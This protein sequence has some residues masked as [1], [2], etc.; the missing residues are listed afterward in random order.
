[1]LP[2]GISGSIS[3]QSLF[4]QVFTK[5]SMSTKVM[6]YQNKYKVNRKFGLIA[7]NNKTLI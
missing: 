2:E 6:L 5:F 1:M 7:E 4:Q 3:R